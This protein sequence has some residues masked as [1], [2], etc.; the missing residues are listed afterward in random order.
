MT[1]QERIVRL[2]NSGIGLEEQDIAAII[3]I[4]VADV[5][6]VLADASHPVTL[7]GG[8]GAASGA[9]ALI[10]MSSNVVNHTLAPGTVTSDSIGVTLS[11]QLPYVLL[12]KGYY[13]GLVSLTPAVALNGAVDLPADL[14]SFQLQVSSLAFANNAQ[15]PQNGALRPIA[16]QEARLDAAASQVQLACSFLVESGPQDVAIAGFTQHDFL[17]VGCAFTVY[18]RR[19]G[20][21][22]DA[23]TNSVVATA[24]LY[25]VKVGAKL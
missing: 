21:P 13:A 9:S 24:S 7:P 6:G 16:S 12:P 22:L 2:L 14:C 4:P 5:R 25:I 19:T 1:L 15:L 11:T 8:G 20:Q 3:G 10:V 18:N 23:A 17:A